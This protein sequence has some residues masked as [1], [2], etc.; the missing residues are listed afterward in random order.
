[1][2]EF[3]TLLSAA[4][5]YCPV[6]DHCRHLA[7]DLQQQP[8]WK[9]DTHA[10]KWFMTNVEQVYRQLLELTSHL[11]A[12]TAQCGSRMCCMHSFTI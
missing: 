9:R 1:M 2:Q 4:W 10:W 12:V 7:L 11:E 3:V 8:A 6:H 5:V